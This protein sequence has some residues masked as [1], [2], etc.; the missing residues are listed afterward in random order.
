MVVKNEIYIVY[1]QDIEGRDLSPHYFFDKYDAC[2]YAVSSKGKI[3]YG[4]PTVYQVT[5]VY[6]TDDIS[7]DKHSQ[8]VRTLPESEIQH[9]VN[10]DD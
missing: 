9:C 5:V 4:M 2:K 7:V 10:G 1:G 6:N 8:S 3:A